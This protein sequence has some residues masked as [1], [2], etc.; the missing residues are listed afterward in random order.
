VPSDAETFV[1]EATLLTLL[2]VA[3]S[4]GSPVREGLLVEAL[5]ERRWR[6][7]NG[8]PI[9]ALSLYDVE[10]FGVLRN[11]TDRPVTFRDRDRFSPVAVALARA[12][13]LAD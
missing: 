6:H 8:E 7:S 10:I 13:L 9:E 12:A 11:V 3:S 2:L 1:Q 5:R 4:S